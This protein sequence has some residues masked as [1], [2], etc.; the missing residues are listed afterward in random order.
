MQ[1]GDDSDDSA[2]GLKNTHQKCCH[3][4]KLQGEHGSGSDARGEDSDSENAS[5]TEEDSGIVWRA[6]EVDSE[7]ACG[8]EGWEL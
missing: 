3:G 8:S 1:K 7:A 5:F 2:A 4:E 6:D